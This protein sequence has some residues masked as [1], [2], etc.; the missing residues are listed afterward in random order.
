M[1]YYGNIREEELKLKVGE[2]FFAAY[3]R[4]AILGNV[5]FCIAART[6]AAAGQLTFDYDRES[7]LWAES[8]RGTVELLD[9]FVQ[10][11]LT[12]GKARTFDRYLPPAFLGAFDAEKIGFVPYSA[13]IDVFYQNDFNWN[14]TPSDHTTK[15]F[16]QLRELVERSFKQGSYVYHYATEAKE[17]SAF[18]KANF[19]SNRQDVSCI[20]VTQNN[21]VSI[22]L[23][24]RSAVMPTIAINW[25]HAKRQG[26][27]DA[28]FY[29]ADLLSEHDLTLKDKL[30]VVLRK[31]RY[32]VNRRIDEMGLFASSAA[33]FTDEQAKHTE[34]WHHYIR[35]PKR[36]YWDYIIE[37]RDLLIPQDV[38]ERKGSF[39]TPSVW[40]AKAQE[41]LAAALGENWQEEYYVWDCCAGTGNLEA[42]L[43]NKYRIWASTL[44]K[45][46]VDVMLDRIANGANLLPSHV[47]Q[48][49]FLNGDFNDIPDG[50]KA[51]INDPEKRRKLVIFINPPYAEAATTRTKSGTGENKP[52]VAAHSLNRKYKPRI[53]AAVN[54]LFALF[55]MRIHEE[56]SGCVLAQ[57]STLKH[58]SAPNFQAFR[59]AFC[60]TL[61]KC[62]VVPAD[63]FDNVK[64]QFP[65]GFFIWSWRDETK[66]T[67]G[68]E[69]TNA[70]GK[71]E[72]VSHPMF[73]SSHV[74]HKS[75]KSQIPVPA[76]AFSSAIADAYDNKDIFIGRK[77][78]YAVSRDRVINTWLHGF[79]EQNNEPIGWLRFVP[80]DFQNN[81]GV[82]ITLKPNESDVRESR[83]AAITRRNFFIIAIYNAVRHCIE[84]TWLNDRDQYLWPNDGW[85]SDREFQ[86]DCL[87]Y[88]IFSR[89]NNIK[90]ADGVNH[91]IPFSEEEVEAQDAYESHFLLDYIA[92]RWRPEESEPGNAQLELLPMVAEETADYTAPIVFSPEAQ[93]VF[94][95]ARP[96]WRYYH[97]QPDANPN[98]SFYEIREHFQGRN[99]RGTMNADSPDATYTAL[100]DA[101]K[102]AYKALSDKIEPKIYAYGFLLG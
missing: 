41:Y 50:L 34:F 63:T 97:S 70:D 75:H 94:D 15:E 61:E 16:Q 71:Q 12:I 83:V 46:D 7:F 25:E 90:S 6:T 96:I 53:G 19:K 69:G 73:N 21:F 79:F 35:P 8:K 84:H 1:T 57:F 47:F 2:E 40:V 28:D 68:T 95:A 66:G 80:N 64:G 98:A 38:R 55:L 9:A 22:Y 51:I 76:T 52:G 92:G 42:G 65:I 74:S 44:D 30:N 67:E 91:W 23:K 17:L 45:S 85:K 43:V 78:I 4:T 18:I 72:G 81:N 59:D 56:I 31:M 88:T 54:E 33:E 86:T 14:V 29:L 39:F 102:A 101:F 89:S 58:L 37:R 20:R 10:L 11:I 93:A 77:T 60:G 82:F 3:D 5:D 48:F 27:L 32:E 62:F 24:W 13:V 87:C 100:L 99:S 26:I 36:D 49:D